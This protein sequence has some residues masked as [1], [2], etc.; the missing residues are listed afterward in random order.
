MNQLQGPH[1]LSLVW[2]RKPLAKLWY[3]PRLEA[4]STD[5][6]EGTGTVICAL[7]VPQKRRLQE[8]RMQTAE[9]AAPAP[10]RVPA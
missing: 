10:P 8:H 2:D 5:T 6:D 9:S 1:V 4:G 7:W 3:L